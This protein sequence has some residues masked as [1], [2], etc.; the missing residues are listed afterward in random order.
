MFNKGTKSKRVTVSYVIYHIKEDGT[1]EEITVNKRIS[2]KYSVK[3]K[4]RYGNH[5]LTLNS[6]NKING[7]PIEIRTN[8]EYYGKRF[9]YT[10][11]D[12]DNKYIICEEKHGVYIANDIDMLVISKKFTINIEHI[13]LDPSTN[14]LIAHIDNNMHKYDD[15]V[16]LLKPGMHTFEHDTPNMVDFGPK[17]YDIKYIGKKLHECYQNGYTGMTYNVCIGIDGYV[18]TITINNSRGINNHIMEFRRENGTKYF[19]MYMNGIVAEFTMNSTERGVILNGTLEYGN[20]RYRGE[21]IYKLNNFYRY[22]GNKVSN[23]I[24]INHCRKKSYVTSNN[25]YR[26]NERITTEHGEYDDMFV[27]DKKKVFSIVCP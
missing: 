8:N 10:D 12:T 2:V 5:M 13:Y 21:F 26:V 3:N 1:K 27:Y 24:I 23:D 7:L 4:D 19:K 18:S 9:V 14:T 11:D 17:V 20:K 16:G 15:H 25:W 22:V 6:C